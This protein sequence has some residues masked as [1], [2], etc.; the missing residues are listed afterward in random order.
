MLNS[1]YLMEKYVCVWLLCLCVRV[2]AER[3]APESRA[4]VKL[5]LAYSPPEETAV[6][7]VSPSGFSSQEEAG[8]KGKIQT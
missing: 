6:N 8:G 3:N 5:C 1:Q 4:W 7:G 2:Y